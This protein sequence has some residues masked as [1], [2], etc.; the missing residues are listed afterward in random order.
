MKLLCHI[1][2]DE[3]LLEAWLLHYLALG[4]QEFH[5]IVHGKPEDNLLLDQLAEG[6]PLHFYHR[7]DGPMYEVVK[8]FWL[9]RALEVASSEWVL[10]V[11]S[12][13]FL[14][15]PFKDLQSTI[16][17]LEKWNKSFL[18]APLLQRVPRDGDLSLSPV[19]KVSDP[20]E[21]FPLAVPDLC[22]QM[23]AKPKLSKFPLFFNGP[24]AKI[25]PGFH[26]PP[27]TNTVDDREFLGVSHHFKWRRNLLERMNRPA[28][29]HFYWSKQEYNIYER[30]LTKHQWILPASTAFVCSRDELWKRN[31]L[32]HPKQEVSSSHL[33]WHVTSGG[34]LEVNK[35]IHEQIA[36]ERDQG[37]DSRLLFLATESPSQ[38]NQTANCPQDLEAEVLQISAVNPLALAEE[39]VAVERLR[40]FFKESNPQEIH[41]YGHYAGWLA[42]FAALELVET[43]FTLSVTK[44]IARSWIW[45]FD[46]LKDLPDAIIFYDR[47]QA[48]DDIDRLG[49]L[50]TRVFFG[51]WRAPLIGP[52]HADCSDI[53][54]EK[55]ERRWR[56]RAA[57]H[58]MQADQIDRHQKKIE[59]L[60]QKRTLARVDR[61]EP[62]NR[63][64]FII[65]GSPRVGSNYVVSLL[66]SHSKIKAYSEVLDPTQSPWN[67]ECMFCEKIHVPMIKQSA[68]SWLRQY[69]FSGHFFQPGI[70]CLGFK[71]LYFHISKHNPADIWQ[72]LRDSKVKIIHL[73]RN[74]YHNYISHQ[75]AFRSDTWVAFAPKHLAEEE[76]L[77]IK[78]ETLEEYFDEVTQ[79]Q[80]KAKDESASLETLHLTYESMFA[81]PNLST[82]FSD[83]LEVPFEPLKAQ[84][85]QQHPGR[86]E[87]YVLNHQELKKHFQGTQYE[88]FFEEAD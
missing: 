42:F 79:E 87:Q 59:I 83:F 85:L 7:Y 16:H 52:G 72:T 41:V 9:N 71:L 21:Q 67:F 55:M 46:L 86:P 73:T 76:P 61:T 49:L 57:F 31:F 80:Q 78:K 35:I 51:K 65:L 77:T 19:G 3:D 33:V 37:K 66:N 5:M 23:G 29:D 30:Y 13:E 20:F 47:E 34:K 26:G 62:A 25:Q 60:R 69:W 10:T 82:L 2:G 58:Q 32:K 28:I 68:S 53:S 63:S 36:L 4:V 14:E 50:A 12:D 27:V 22:E 40:K 15:L 74:L 39:K 6:Y 64:Y 43:R 45:I 11:D 1:S 84:T 56:S 48:C 8:V 24:G 17:Q 38:I 88:H 75:F 18:A 54:L 81:H 70:Q 44:E